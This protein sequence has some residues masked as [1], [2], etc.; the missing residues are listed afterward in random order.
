MRK[1][2]DSPPGWRPGVVAPSGV[3][4]FRGVRRS[5]RGQVKAAEVPRARSAAA[6]QAYRESHG[7][8]RRSA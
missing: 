7:S 2:P 3:S 1:P 4:D 5:G 8:N 6:R